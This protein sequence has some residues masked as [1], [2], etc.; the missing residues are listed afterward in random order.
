MTKTMRTILV[1]SLRNTFK[2][3]V[4]K[5]FTVVSFNR[6]TMDAYYGILFNKSKPMLT[7][8]KPSPQNGALMTFVLDDNLKNG[9][10]EFI[11]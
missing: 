3:A 7:T 10:L 11:V 6:K 8:G 9:Q 1:N 4:S 5:G 2:E